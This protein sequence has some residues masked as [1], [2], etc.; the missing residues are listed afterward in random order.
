M[1]TFL[2]AM[3]FP[4]KTVYPVSS[5]NEK[6]F[7]NL[8]SVYL[9]AV[10]RPAIYKN[11]N[12]FYQEGWHYE[13]EEGGEPIY[14]GVVFN[15]MK[16]AFSSPDTRL[17]DGLMGMMF[18]D[19]SYGWVS[20]GHPAHIPELTYEEFLTA[21]RDFYS[22]ANC[23]IYLDGSVPLEATL[24]MIDGYLSSAEELGYAH[25]VVMQEPKP[26]AEVTEYY[27]AP[28]NGD[29]MLIA[30]Q[31]AGGWDDRLKLTALS[32]LAKYLTGSNEAPLKKAV[33]ESGIAKD[34]SLIVEDS[35]AQPFSALMVRQLDASRKDELMA[36]IRD[37]AATHK[38]NK[39]DLR[40]TMDQM[41]FSVRDAQEPK[42]LM[43]NIL[44]LN[45]WLFGG[46]LM[47]GMTFTPLFKA[48][49]EKLEGDYFDALLAE[50]T[51]DCDGSA[52]LLLLPSPK[53]GEE[54]RAEEAA[55]L[56]A[57]SAKWTDADRA[58]IVEMNKK[59]SAWQ[60]TP[61]SE[62]DVAKLPVLP[63]E[64]ISRE[65][66]CISTEVTEIGGR[67]ALYHKTSSGEIVHY[68]FYF[69]LGD[70]TV[71]EIRTLSFMTNLLG[72]LPTERHSVTELE[73]MTKSTLGHLDY[74]VEIY[75]DRC[76]T[77][78][79]KP[80]FTVSFSALTHKE[81][82][83]LALVREIITETRFTGEELREI[84][85]IITAQGRESMYHGIMAGGNRF[86]SQRASSHFFA[87]SALEEIAG[88]YDFYC[89][90]KALEESFDGK[91]GDIQ[92]ELARL[93]EAVFASSRVTVSVAAG[94][95]RD[96]AAAF[97]AA[98]PAGEA[99]DESMTYPT[100]GKT[101]SEAI[102]IP[103]PVA[104]AAMSGK[105]SAEYTGGMA[106]LGNV[107]NYDYL[108]NEVRVKGGAYGCGFRVSAAGNIAFSSYRDPSPV[109]SVKTFAAADEFLGGFVKE[110][111]DLTQH[112]I[113]AAASQE[114][115]LHERMQAKRAAADYLVGITAE[116]RNLWRRQLLEMTPEA[117]GAASQ[118]LKSSEYARCIVG[119]EN[120]LTEA[121][122]WDKHSL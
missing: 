113:G 24:T 30:G 76:D 61:D 16:G 34:A 83:A 70:K 93:A 86:A 118:W 56:A 19:T 114:P 90:L 73:L 72:Q 23:F 21:H 29:A 60:A 20:G 88:G 7:L 78:V 3:T 102:V 15:E 69:S 117:L 26:H 111:S 52:T 1:N 40:A 11:P 2:N 98:L 32:V 62:E 107:M 97:I 67:P 71:R 46:D 95:M 28:E 80:Y 33:L 48:L 39:A 5:R 96:A 36:L 4:D 18:P 54:E 87:A 14:N 65:V 74:S 101:V 122:G 58:A 8:T 42:A 13:M 108:W 9:D 116:E 115:L 47:D 6:D 99:C 112:I 64:E 109:N 57:A 22:P 68:V 100:D 105:C 49:G 104:Y 31:P 91:I 27:E 17:F 77:Q 92:A 103:A 43:R 81:A 12:I 82:D 53:K 55:R 66:A 50:L 44:G 45:T 63:I 51:F 41:E 119:G 75:Q 121:D 25:E 94:D 59:L 35:V 79:C 37:F 38:I 84:I 110:T 89:H 85:R 10:F 106:L 120:T